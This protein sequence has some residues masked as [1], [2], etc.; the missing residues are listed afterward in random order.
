[1]IVLGSL[2]MIKVPTQ[3]TML[4]VLRGRI[5]SKRT[6][7][8]YWPLRFLKTATPSPTTQLRERRRARVPAVS[9]ESARAEQDKFPRLFFSVATKNGLNGSK[10]LPM[11]KQQLEAGPY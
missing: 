3:I 8:R 9:L 11:A 7:L 1:M 5:P 10:H 2:V 6:D 4:L